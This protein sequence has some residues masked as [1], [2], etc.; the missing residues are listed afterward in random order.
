MPSNTTKLCQKV[1]PFHEVEV[2]G[3][4]SFKLE[5]IPVNEMEKEKLMKNV[6]NEV[7]DKCEWCKQRVKSCATI[8]K[9]LRLPFNRF[10]GSLCPLL[11]ADLNSNVMVRLLDCIFI[12]EW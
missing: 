7:K 9:Y 10:A 3:Q 12:S 5:K 6:V 8:A 4:S 2:P 1:C 11:H